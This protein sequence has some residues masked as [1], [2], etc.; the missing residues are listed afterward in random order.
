LGPACRVGNIFCL[1]SLLIGINV[2]RFF[3]AGLAEL[4]AIWWGACGR[5]VVVWV[6][7]YDGF[8]VPVG[9][10]VSAA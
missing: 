6:A 2:I 9:L 1:G 4:S 10:D 5:A 7:S 3:G 8:S